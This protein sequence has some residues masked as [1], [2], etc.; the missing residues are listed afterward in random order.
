MSRAAVALAVLVLA[1][2]AAGVGYWRGHVAGAA[3]VQ[4]AWDKERAA[5]AQASRAAEKEQRAI[6]QARQTEIERISREAKSQ[7]AAAQSDAVAA[8]DAAG[9]LQQR[10]AA[11]V[12][13]SRA[14]ADP[15]VAGRGQGEQGADA[16]D[17]LVGMQSRLD[18]AAGQLADYADKVRVA[19]LA[20]ERAYDNVKTV[21]AS[22]LEPR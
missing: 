5:L 14:S 9:R 10:V 22:G 13:A 12:A 7:I 2:L 6:E 21:S 20:C 8:R 11:L 18:D 1:L 4:Q 3:G 16:L 15:G 17:L 19:G